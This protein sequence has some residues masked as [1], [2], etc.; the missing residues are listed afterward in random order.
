MRGRER[1]RVSDTKRY[2]V[3]GFNDNNKKDRDTKDKQRGFPD[4]NIPTER[5][6]MTCCTEMTDVQINATD[7]IIGF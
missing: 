1:F 4:E 2:K 7:N 5:N 3:K 6:Y